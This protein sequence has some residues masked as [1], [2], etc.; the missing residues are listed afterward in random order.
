MSDTRDTIVIIS[1]MN[2]Y[3]LPGSDILL[4]DP[5]TVRVK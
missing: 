4:E 5:E 1:R 2:F 3:D